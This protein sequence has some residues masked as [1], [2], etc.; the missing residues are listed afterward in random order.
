MDKLPEYLTIRKAAQLGIVSEHALRQME[1]R[2]EL[3]TI[4]VGSRTLINKDA[5][6]EQMR[7]VKAKSPMT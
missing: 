5:F 3:P 6:I 2:G 1:K 4:R 7:N